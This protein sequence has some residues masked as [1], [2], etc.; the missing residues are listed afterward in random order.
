MPAGRFEISL[1]AVLE[2]LRIAAPFTDAVFNELP[3]LP[4]RSGIIHGLAL[5]TSEALTNAIRHSDRPDSCVRLVLQLC[6]D[7]MIIA[8]TDQ[9]AGFDPDAVA[10]PDLESA[11]EGGYGLYIINSL[12]DEVRYNREDD[13]NTL[14]LT[15]IWGE[16]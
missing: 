3:E 7:R 6:S 15:K 13:G 16:P 2:S 9:G 14:V 4:D 10:P 1:P 11:S 12:M 8:V 5:V